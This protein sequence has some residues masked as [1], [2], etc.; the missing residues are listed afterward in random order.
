MIEKLNQFLSDMLNKEKEYNWHVTK[1]VILNINSNDLW[2][3]ISNPSNLENFHPFCKKNPTIKW[4]GIDSIDQIHYYNNMIYERTFYEWTD[5][6]GYK[7]EI[8][9]KKSYKSLVYWDIKKEGKKSELSIKI[10]PHLLNRG[11]KIIYFFPFFFIVKP[12]LES[13]LNTVFKGLEYHIQT[14]KKVKKN[15]FGKHP[16]FTI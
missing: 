16:W 9:K 6:K 3:I 11:K 4:P 1:N 2:N 5:K 13:Y 7:L 14:K 10:I 8:G 15:Q 12:R